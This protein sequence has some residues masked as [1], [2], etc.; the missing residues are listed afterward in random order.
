MRRPEESTEAQIEAARRLSMIPSFFGI[1]LVGVI[2]FLGFASSASAVQLGLQFQSLEGTETQMYEIAQTGTQVWRLQVEPRLDTPGRYNKAFEQAALHGITILPLVRAEPATKIIAN[3]TEKN[4]WGEWL[5]GVVRR[6]GYNGSFWAQ[7]PD[8]PAKPAT[9]WEVLNEPNLSGAD[10]FTPTQ[11]G[12]LIAWAGPLIQN[13]STNQSGRTTEVLFGGLFMWGVNSAYEGAK[14]YLREAYNV[15]GA[16]SGITGIAIHPYELDPSSFTKP[17]LQESYSR[18]EAF[19]LAVAGI[20]QQLNISSQMPGGSSKNLWITE[21]GWPAEGPEYAVT[22][23]Q[24]AELLKQTFDYA[25]NN[26]ANLKLQTILWYNYADAPVSNWAGFCGI[27][28]AN[29][30]ARQSWY[31][32]QGETGAPVG[33]PRAP[34]ENLVGVQMNNTGEHHTGVHVLSG[35]SEYQTWLTQR[36]TPLGETTAAQWHFLME[37]Y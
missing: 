33:P 20:H 34:V 36:E 27:R 2:A 6:Y 31:A 21:D 13:A 37:E 15:S 18:I 22:E 5:D 16:A 3:Q 29:L 28:K 7:H 1:L 12:Q 35:A 32:F 23:A 19:Q 10:H 24:Q 8:I 11:Y 26:A 14:S 17:K 4:A 9:A 30:T 25:K